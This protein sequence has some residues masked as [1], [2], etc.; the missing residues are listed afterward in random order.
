MVI[1]FEYDW[2]FVNYI[3]D[4]MKSIQV[5]NFRSFQD[6]GKIEFKNINLFLGKNSSG[7]SS[8]LRLFPLFKQSILHEL[9]GPLMWYDE[10]YDYGSFVNVLNRKPGG[11]G[12]MKFL[13]EVELPSKHCLDT[14]CEDCFVYE[15]KI[16]PFLKDSATCLLEMVVDGDYKGTFLQEI[17]LRLDNHEI[18]LSSKKRAGSVEIYLDNVKLNTSPVKWLYK[19]TGLF[20]NMT[21]K[22][23]TGHKF[24]IREL[25]KLS[26]FE[27]LKTPDVD[28]L[29]NYPSF[30]EENIYEY[31]KGLNHNPLAKVLID[32]YKLNTERFS[33][34]CGNMNLFAI[35]RILLFIDKLLQVDFRKSSYIEPI[36]FGFERYIRNK[37]FTVNEI[38]SSGNN[39]VDYIQSLSKKKK[40]EFVKF[41][42]E[43]LGI[44]I[45]ISNEDSK[46]YTDN[47]SIYVVVDGE[48]DNIVDVGQGYSQVLPIA[49]M[50]WDVASK[51]HKCEFTDTIVIEQPE[52]HLHPSMQADMVKLFL[53]ALRLSKKR[54]NPIR[55][56]IETHSPVIVNRIGKMI[57]LKEVKS[58]EVSVFLFNKENGISSIQSTSYGD[59]GRIKKWPIG[60]LD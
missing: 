54:N 32:S 21:S 43:S 41:I 55:L 42:K 58:E 18:S 12:K 34:L 35:E 40:N 28:E 25:F 30:L 8:I 19:T 31:L 27:S 44:E 10:T 45:L 20:P 38:T 16:N 1:V 22:E 2:M 26:G 60:F 51:Q 17:K 57:R 9:R 47:Q 13:I 53:N 7:K 29:I 46:T 3:N 59:D 33:L 56:V 37:D 14:R 39:V 4:D 5:K 6:S 49:V 24:L 48:K 23:P 15:D 11:D 52:V 36:R 50:L